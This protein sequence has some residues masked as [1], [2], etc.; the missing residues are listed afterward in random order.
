MS[1]SRSMSTFSKWAIIGLG[2]MLVLS[3][4]GIFLATQTEA[5]FAWI[6][7]EPD[8]KSLQILPAPAFAYHELQVS[9]PLVRTLRTDRSKNPNAPRLVWSVNGQDVDA[10][11]LVLPAGSFRRGDL[12][13]ARIE[14]P[15]GEK[16]V[17]TNDATIVVSNAPPHVR[18]AYLER[19]ANRPHVAIL[20]VEATDPDDDPLDHRVTW[21]LDGEP[22][23]GTHG[24]RVDISAIES[25]QSVQAQVVVSDGE[26][27]VDHLT[28]PLGVDNQPPALEVAARP[29]IETADDGSRLAIL[30]ASSV[31]PDGD[32]VT[33]AAVDAPSG[34][35]WD[36][37][38]QALVWSVESGTESF[39][40]VLRADDRR[41]GQAERTITLRR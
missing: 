12:V 15:G 32:A 28:A 34:V 11:G 13:R 5:P 24:M 10:D 8:Q 40:V 2:G 23:P 9:G 21:L 36:G 30:A 33:I 25:G 38:R 31:D 17:V 1:E 35:R 27:K 39:D 3:A 20:H 14:V 37:N 4:T 26:A 19:P 41:G 7:P 16:P 18:A 22:W 29:E 6:R